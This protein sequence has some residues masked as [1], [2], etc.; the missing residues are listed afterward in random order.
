MCRKY[1]DQHDK[2]TR[3]FMF[4]WSHE[5]GHG[6]RRSIK[7]KLHSL[8]TPTVCGNPTRDKAMDRRRASRS[9]RS[10]SRPDQ[11]H[12]ARRVISIQNNKI[13]NPIE[14]TQRL[15]LFGSSI[16]DVIK[17]KQVQTSIIMNNATQATQQQ[18][19]FVG[20]MSDSRLRCIPHKTSG[21]SD[22][23][24]SFTNQEVCVATA[25]NRIEERRAQ[26]VNAID[27]RVNRHR[28]R[29][30][31]WLLFL[32]WEL[33]RMCFMTHFWSYLRS[34]PNGAVLRP[35]HVNQKKE[36]E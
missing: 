12:Q 8:G 3:S 28:T 26:H 15:V 2:S 25:A 6:G 31:R 17:A 32:E 30:C 35:P 7:H 10:K 22:N 5:P 29:M 11:N 20:C 24:E 18:D 34:C 16:S 21:D 19:T 36:I 27:E 9:I 14:G 13:V 4:A 1:S 23:E 33:P